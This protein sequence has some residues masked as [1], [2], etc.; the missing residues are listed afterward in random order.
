MHD[1]LFVVFLLQFQS[2]E[3]LQQFTLHRDVVLF[4][5]VLDQ[6]LRDGGSA[7]VI[8]HAQ[9]H[10]EEC[11]DGTVPVHALVGVE[12]LVLDGDD[13]LFHVLG[14]VVIVHPDT[15]LRTGQ[16]D[17][18]LPVAVGSFIENGAGLLDGEIIQT[19]IDV[20]SDRG[21]DVVCKNASEQQCGQYED[22][23]DR[24]K[25]LEHASNGAAHGTNRGAC[26]AGSSFLLLAHEWVYL[27]IWIPLSH[28]LYH[29]IRKKK[30]ET[31][32]IF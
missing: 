3:D 6:L 1:I 10:I 9:E 22:Q 16:L 17:E 20:R 26:C 4:G 27:H 24:A 14:D 12:A 32:K 19:D 30:T 28:E 5:Q 21:F 11:T 2:L 15:F 18:L 7:E 31:K 13:R 23:K 25:D 8:A 29:I